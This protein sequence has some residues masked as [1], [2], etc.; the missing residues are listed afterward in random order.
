MNKFRAS[1]RVAITVMVL[2]LLALFGC[3]KELDSDGYFTCLPEK[4][5]VF[6]NNN[7]AAA[8]TYVYDYDPV[9]LWPKTI[10]ITIPASSYFKILD[11]DVNG[12]TINLGADG[13][14]EMD[15]SRRITHLEVKKP[16]AGAEKGD[17]F[18]GYDSEGFL[19]ERLYDDGGPFVERTVFLN[20]GAAIDS[21][22]VSYE[23]DHNKLLASLS[24]QPA[25]NGNGENLLP[26]TDIFPELLPFAYLVK[27]G[28]ISVDIPDR[29]KVLVESPGTQTFTL[30][31][32]YSGYQFD[33]NELLT[34][35]SSRLS[36][37][38]MP[39]YLRKFGITYMCK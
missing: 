7:A 9:T 32:R 29:M 1:P 33:A 10:A 30:N 25:A 11:L 16:F 3:Q 39:D 26:Y 20:D 17:Y 31:F 2:C 22:T 13:L 37:A 35:F 36:V 15:V 23:L 27:L 4:I 28:R 6:E 34:G 19:A 12:N 14:I 18:Y 5:E 24:F 8:E 21:F 38:G